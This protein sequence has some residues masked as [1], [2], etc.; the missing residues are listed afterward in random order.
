MSIVT[1]G[2][3]EEGGVVTQGYGEDQPTTPVVSGIRML[4][5]ADISKGTFIISPAP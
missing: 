3:G 5:R 1:Q 4:F 2:L